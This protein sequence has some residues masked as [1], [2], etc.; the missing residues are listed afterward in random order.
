[1]K[2]RE[3]KMAALGAAACALLVTWRAKADP[4]T[5]S[6]EQGYDL[7]EIQ[8]PRALAFGGAQN[9]LGVSTTALY[10]NPANLPLSRVYH[11]EGLATLSPEAR[12]QSYGGAVV[13]SS[14]SRLSGGFGGTWSIMDP[15]GIKRTWTDLRLVLAY[16][17]GDRI[18]FGV[19]GR[20]LRVAQQ[21]SSGPL[22]AS[23]ASDG[24]AKGP[25]FNAFSVDVGAT[26]IPVNGFRIG[27]AGH[28][29]TNPGTALAPTTVAGGIGYANEIFALEADA[30]A[31]F[32]T[33]SG[34]R[35]RFMLGGEV[36]LANHFP[37]RAGYRYDDGFKTHAV[38][39]GLGYID[40]KWSFE[41]GVRRDV[42]GEHPATVVSVSLRFFYDSARGGDAE[43]PEA[44]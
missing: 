29:L 42:A 43:A 10:N 41:A 8:S 4:A 14:T 2:L 5:T 40:R 13:D 35:G 37:I 16:P 24:T 3:S 44:F 33:W 30:L 9:A 26:V 22:G 21:T 11:F 39:G 12:R 32:T 25:L 27:V 6:P 36:F 31:D 38:S 23:Y 28:N 18:S 15:D 17:L 19:T 7:G 34:T 20:Y 1:M